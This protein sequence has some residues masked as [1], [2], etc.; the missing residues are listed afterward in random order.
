M[1]TY[2][3]TAI[4]LQAIQQGR[5]NYSTTVTV[6]PI[7]KRAFIDLVEGASTDSRCDNCDSEYKREGK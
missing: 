1:A 5:A 2:D 3:L 6:C 4:S 7:C